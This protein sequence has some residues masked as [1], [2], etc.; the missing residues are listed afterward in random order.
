[1]MF[2]YSTLRTTTYTVQYPK[3][4]V[5]YPK[6]SPLLLFDNKQGIVK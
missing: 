6:S 1:M 3:Y 4:T 5:Q 2:V